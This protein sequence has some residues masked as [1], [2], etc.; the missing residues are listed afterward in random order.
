VLLA[1]VNGHSG[2]A[3]PEGSPLG[4]GREPESRMELAK[5]WIPAFAG[6]T[7]AVYLYFL[8]IKSATLLP[9]SMSALRLLSPASILRAAS[10][11]CAAFPCGTTATPAS[12]A[13]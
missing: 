4:G 13:Q 12:S 8:V 9:A 7:V 10:S 6:M 2:Q 5:P 1:S 3:R 11:T